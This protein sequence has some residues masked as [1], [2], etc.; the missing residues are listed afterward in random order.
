MKGRDWFWFCPLL[1]LQFLAQCPAHSGPSVIIGQVKKG[2]DKKSLQT[3]KKNQVIIR[4]VTTI[5]VVVICIPKVSVRWKSLIS[6]IVRLFFFLP[7]PFTWCPT[8]HLL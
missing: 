1:F 6:H 4:V 3:L 5:T 2:M 7:M 8:S